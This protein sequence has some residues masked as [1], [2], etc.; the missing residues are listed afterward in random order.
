MSD[1]SKT[2]FPQK[3]AAGWKKHERKI[4]IATT[5]LSIG[6]AVLMRSGINQHNEFL[7]ERGLYEEFYALYED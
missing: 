6:S 3:L 1:S 4:L 2:T 5:A 7:K